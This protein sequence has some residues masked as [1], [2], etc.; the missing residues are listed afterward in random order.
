LETFKMGGKVIHTVKYAYSLVLM[1][2]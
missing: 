1:A 2:K